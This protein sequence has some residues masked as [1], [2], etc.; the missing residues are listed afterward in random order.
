[1]FPYLKKYLNKYMFK[2][3]CHCASLTIQGLHTIEKEILN[4]LFNIHAHATYSYLCPHQ[5]CPFSGQHPWNPL[6]GTIAAVAE[7]MAD[8]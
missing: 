5:K 8:A 3:L 6:E 7:V 1:M 4:V 2:E